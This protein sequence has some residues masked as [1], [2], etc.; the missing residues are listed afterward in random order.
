MQENLVLRQL[1]R[2][3]SNFIGDGAG[4]ILPKMGW[5]VDDFHN[6]LNR[7][8]TDTAWES[9]QRHK[10]DEGGSSSSQKRPSEDDAGASRSKRPRGAGDKEDDRN[11]DAY[12]LIVPM[13]QAVPPVPANNLYPPQ[14]RNA[15]ENALFNDLMRGPSGSPMFVPPTS[16]PNSSGQYASPSTTG[17]GAAH[18][19][20]QSSYMPP[21]NV[22][23]DSALPAMSLVSNMPS[24][25]S[26]NSQASG[27]ESDQDPK[28]EEALK[29]IQSVSLQFVDL[30]LSDVPVG[31]QVSS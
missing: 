24:G 7:S 1:L 4:G 8:E 14:S 27:E 21:M 2:S 18:S 9:Y 10:R 30:R 16:P 22:S 29:L 11:G 12:P 17:V 3:L 28:R 31:D 13:N 23:V 19:S 5:T 25:V 26:S 6:F 20:Y 15:H